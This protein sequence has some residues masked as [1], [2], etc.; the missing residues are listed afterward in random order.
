MFGNA[1]YSWVRSS[2]QRSTSRSRNSAKH[3]GPPPAQAASIAARRP[4][5]EV[6]EPRVVGGP[7]SWL[8]GGVRV[9]RDRSGAADFHSGRLTTGRGRDDQ[10]R[11]SGGLAGDIARMRIRLFALII[12]AVVLL[13][14]AAPASADDRSV[15]EA[16][17]K[18]DARGERLVKQS[19]STLK[20]WERSEFRV[21]KPLVRAFDALQTYAS[22]AE[23]RLKTESPSTEQGA[24]A[25]ALALKAA[26]RE[27]QAYGNL[28]YA[29][30]LT[31]DG[32][33][34]LA[35][36]YLKS[37]TRMLRVADRYTRR[38]NRAFKALGFA[39]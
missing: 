3:S 13:M 2:A 9:A 1:S 11:L 34:R 38:A 16:W 6:L 30:N 23:H 31:V 27:W 5:V 14:S 32:Q 24:K 33:R 19:Q 4:S 12:V 22:D 35:R 37:G 36:H 29:V 39:T 10:W 21:W 7:G 28:R 20:R 18:D 26:Q 8:A 25:R 17:I 15:H